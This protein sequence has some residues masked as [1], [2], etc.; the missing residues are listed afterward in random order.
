MICSS[1][2]Q[3][4]GLRSE[5]RSGLQLFDQISQVFRHHRQTMVIFISRGAARAVFFLVEVGE[6]AASNGVDMARSCRR[7]LGFSSDA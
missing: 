4:Q 2:G 3:V 1:P 6:G 7:A 5:F